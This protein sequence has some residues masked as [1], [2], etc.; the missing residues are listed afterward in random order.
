MDMSGSVIDKYMLYEL[1]ILYSP[2]STIIFVSNKVLK[3]RKIVQFFSSQSDQ[4][5]QIDK[6]VLIDRTGAVM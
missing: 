5:G 2:R 6:F 1:Y 4:A 3:C